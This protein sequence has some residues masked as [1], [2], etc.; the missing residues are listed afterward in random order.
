MSRGKFSA[1]FLKNL[2]L[3]NFN[4]NFREKNRQGCQNSVLGAQRN[5]LRKKVFAFYFSCKVSKKNWTP[6]EKNIYLQGSKLHSTCSGQQFSVL[7]KFFKTYHVHMEL[8]KE[9]KQ[10]MKVKNKGLARIV[11]VTKLPPLNKRT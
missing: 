2:K 7:K 3:K 6:S 11:H 1:I 5:I 9:R 4:R 10:K 8:A